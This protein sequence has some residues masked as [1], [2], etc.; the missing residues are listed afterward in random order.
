[1]IITQIYSYTRP[2]KQDTESTSNNSKK[3]KKKDPFPKTVADACQILAGWQ[4][5]YGNSTEYTEAK[6]RV[7]FATTCTTEYAGIKN[8]KDKKKHITCFKCKKSGH[9][10]NKFPE[11]GEEKG[12]MGQ[13]F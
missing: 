1:M 5:V 4:N 11:D 8:K 3:E 6:E 7:A 10:L 2:I 13:I 12:R 9:Y